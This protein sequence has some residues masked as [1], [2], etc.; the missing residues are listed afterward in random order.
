MT[1]NQQ[2]Q[3]GAMNAEH[4]QN[5]A[6]NGVEFVA[7]VVSMPIE[8]MLRPWAGSRYF[9]VPVAFFSAL[10]MMA[11]PL[12]FLVMT[13]FLQMIPFAHMATPRGMFDFASFF[14]L[15]MLLCAFHSVRI[16]RRMLR[17]ELEDHSRFEGPPL[18]IFSLVPWCR[19]F[20]KTRVIVEP[21]FVLLVSMVFARPVHRP[22]AACDLPEDCGL[23]A[24]REASDELVSVLGV[25][26][27]GSR[28]EE[29]GPCPCA[30]GGQHSQ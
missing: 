14:Q 30:A 13:S 1:P 27:P 15:Y 6:I 5:T 22:V 28:H 20:W 7:S 26:S 9:S 4:L 21:L 23:H 17:P 2:D 19:S 11:L 3:T 29:R 25:G 16:A 12:F 8:M 10:L 24:G 18:P